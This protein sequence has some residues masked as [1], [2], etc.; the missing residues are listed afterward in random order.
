MLP[1]PVIFSY[2]GVGYSPYRK[3]LTYK[4]I[5]WILLKPPQTAET[6]TELL[7]DPDAVLHPH[8]LPRLLQGLTAQ[9]LQIE[10]HLPSIRPPS[11]YLRYRHTTLQKMANS[12]EALALPT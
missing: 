12:I 5:Y 1:E 8:G 4:R 10:K 6:C 7:T 3:G 11:I 9:E 2:Y